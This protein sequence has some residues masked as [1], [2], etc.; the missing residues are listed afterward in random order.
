MWKIILFFCSECKKNLGYS[1]HIETG[2]PQVQLFN[3]TLTLEKW[4]ELTV[5]KRKIIEIL[6]SDPIFKVV[7]NV[8]DTNLIMK[9]SSMI[10]SIFWS[11]VLNLCCFKLLKIQLVRKVCKNLIWWNG[12]CLRNELYSINRGEIY[13]KF[14]KSVFFKLM[15]SDHYAIHSC[16]NRSS[17]IWIFILVSNWNDIPLVVVLSNFFLFCPSFV[18]LIRCPSI[19]FGIFIYI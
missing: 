8:K 15:W 1:R 14:C 2:P 18:F 4:T 17:S 10:K 3:F 5:F 16:N 9:R 12:R 11:I 13:L 7:D 19:S 6:I